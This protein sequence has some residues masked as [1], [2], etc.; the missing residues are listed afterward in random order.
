MRQSPQGGNRPYNSQTKYKD[1]YR[2]K[3]TPDHIE[4]KTSAIDSTIDWG[5]YNNSWETDEFF[6]LFN[7]QRTVSIIPK[8]AFKNDSD[9]S[10][11]AR[12]ISEKFGDNAV[13]K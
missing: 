12:L 9:L 3:F 10:G 11:F 4:F 1:E 5:F 7:T 13:K 6:Y 8:R 2:L